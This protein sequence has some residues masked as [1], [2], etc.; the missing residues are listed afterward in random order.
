MLTFQRIDVSRWYV[1]GYVERGRARRKVLSDKHLRQLPVN[2]KRKTPARCG[3]GLGL[4]FLDKH[5]QAANDKARTQ[6]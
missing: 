2:T 3:G 6:Y 5:E 1:R 4:V